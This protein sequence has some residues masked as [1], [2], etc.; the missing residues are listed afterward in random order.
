MTVWVIQRDDGV[1]TDGPRRVNGDGDDLEIL[2]RKYE[3]AIVK[4]W[5]VELGDLSFTAR[6]VRGMNP[7]MC[8]RK[9]WIE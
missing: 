6:K 1:V 8:E 2:R 5:I 7:R 9:F 3:G 4:G